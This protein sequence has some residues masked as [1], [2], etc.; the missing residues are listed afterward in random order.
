MEEY[1]RY[2]CEKCVNIFISKAK[3]TNLR[4]RKGEKGGCGS[5]LVSFIEN[6]TLI[7]KEEPYEI[8]KEVTDNNIKYFECPSCDFNRIVE[9]TA[10][11]PNCEEEISW[12]DKERGFFDW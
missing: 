5:T 12:N 9:G 6:I 3:G 10:E 4:C 2:K 11:C 1:N 7:R 8:K